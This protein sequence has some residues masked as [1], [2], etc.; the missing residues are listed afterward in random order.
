MVPVRLGGRLWGFLGF[1]DCQGEREWS[2]VEILALRVAADTL[3][4]AIAARERGAAVAASEERYRALFDQSLG[5]LCTH[6]LDGRI[7]TVNG[8]AAAA[9]GR[10]PDQMGGHNLDEFLAPTVRGQLADYLAAITAKGEMSGTMIL[11]DD[12]GGERVW[13]YRNH[14]VREPGQNPYVVGHALDVT[15]RTRL[16]R[17]LREQALTD[18]L[19][20][21]ANRALFE[22]RLRRALERAKREAVLLGEMPPLTLVYLDLDGFKEVNDSFGHAAGDALLRE[23][24]SR[25]GED[26]RTL[27]TVARLGGDEF[28]LILPNLGSEADA[29][30]LIERLLERL[31]RPFNQ[32]GAALAVR[33][34]LGISMLPGDGA[35]AE[36]LIARADKA[37]YAAKAAGGNAYRF[38][39]DALDI[40][41]LGGGEG[42]AGTGN[43]G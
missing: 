29:R 40:G 13:Q 42:S 4:A 43:P 10:S 34:S 31:R 20:G 23:I 15:D 6:A 18:P 37:M 32:N 17:V 36:S 28:A 5:L 1:D 33:V 21:L 7:L 16:E 41:D 26:L 12:S 38:S 30:R 35:D 3:G 9:L 22:D 8:A 27:D 14:L 19:T 25:L 24:A 2:Q 39:V 11:L